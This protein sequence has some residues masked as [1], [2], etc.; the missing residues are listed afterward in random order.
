MNYQ[1]LIERWRGG[2]LDAW[3]AL[4]EEQIATGLSH[5]R[6]G[7]LQRWV[8]AL[9]A[10]PDI[11][12]DS[13][14]LDDSK[15][16]AHT[17]SPIDEAMRDQLHEALMGLH[18]WRKGPFDLFGVHIDTEWRSD[19]KWDRLAGSIDAL[20][21]RRVLDVG[22][23]S[24]YHC[25]R[26]AGAG[27]SE[28]IGIDPTPLFIVQFWAL[29]KYLQQPGVWV[30]PAGIEH[31]PAKLQA[32]DTVFS[33]GVLYHRRSPMDHLQELKD[34][35][36]PG[37]QLVLETLV[38]EGGPGD[39]LVPEGR[40]A[41]MGNVWFLPSCDTLL[42]WLRKLGFNDAEVVD[43]TVTSTDEQRA[44]PWMTFHSLADFLDPDDPTKSI[45]GY[46]APTRAVVVAR[47]P[48]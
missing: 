40:Y 36:R 32:F 20:E 21:G 9:D 38:I 39:T 15:V 16:G 7:D 41:R 46:P 45:E 29:Q 1:P 23:G 47:K 10:L 27:A 28:V 12:P 17:D 34:C 33:M 42:G 35:L 19:W 5:K 2:E 31:V 18:P 11:T 48:A 8:D 4:L 25:W 6:Y 30:L 22:C 43:V 3:A 44:T 14:S 26:M 24:G 13:L 37:G